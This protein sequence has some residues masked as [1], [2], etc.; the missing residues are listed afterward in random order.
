MD[1]GRITASLVGAWTLESY[2]SRLL[3]G[4]HIQYPLGP[5]ATGIILYTPDGY[6]SAQIMRIDRPHFATDDSN[7][8]SRA[9]SPRLRQ[10]ISPTPAPTPRPK[11]A[12]KYTTTSP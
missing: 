1:A 9:N 12:P 5:D 8:P 7:M 3:E 11:T 2:Q 4:T 10:A 6:M